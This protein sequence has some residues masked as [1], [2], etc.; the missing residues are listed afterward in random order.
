MTKNPT[1]Y[2]SYMLRMCLSDAYPA[3]LKRVRLENVA[4]AGEVYHFADL[5]KMV[6]FLMET[7]QLPA[8]PLTE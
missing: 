5:T 1:I 8:V 2:K 7:L 4:D 3:E 6:D